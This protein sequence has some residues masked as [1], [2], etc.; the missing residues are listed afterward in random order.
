MSVLWFVAVACRRESL[1]GT[2][3]LFHVSTWLRQA[4]TSRMKE[5]AYPGCKRVSPGKSSLRLASLNEGASLAHIDKRCEDI[6]VTATKKQT[7]FSRLPNICLLRDLAH[8]NCC[9]RPT[10]RAHVGT[11]RFGFTKTLIF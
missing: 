7:H 10:I 6:R 3:P 9:L 1:H 4:A 8:N 11:A 2:A 5:T